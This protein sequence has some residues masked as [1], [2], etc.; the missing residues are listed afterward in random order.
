VLTEQKARESARLCALGELLTCAL[1]DV[2]WERLVAELTTHLDGW[3]SKKRGVRVYDVALL[4]GP[5]RR[6][7]TPLVRMARVREETDGEVRRM[8]YFDGF[9]YFG[10]AVTSVVIRCSTAGAVHLHI[11]D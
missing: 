8:V 10:R 3:V 9:T 5:E 7:A 6:G 2:F 1:G 11:V 4:L